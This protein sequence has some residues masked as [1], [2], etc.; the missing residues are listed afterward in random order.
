MR[1]A[2]LFTTAE[3]LVSTVSMQWHIE[4]KTLKVKQQ[5]LNIMDSGTVNRCV[6]SISVFYVLVFLFSLVFVQCSKAID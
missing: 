3:P 4:K 1:H 5:V 2:G 6:L